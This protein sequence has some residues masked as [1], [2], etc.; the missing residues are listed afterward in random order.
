[1]LITQG[2]VADEDDNRIAQKIKADA[3]IVSDTSEVQVDSTCGMSHDLHLY[4]DNCHSKFT[5]KFYECTE[6][7]T[8]IQRYPIFNC[9]VI[10]ILIL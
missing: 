10:R 9:F 1:M 8:V 6:C 5:V 4:V 3:S 7:E 2:P